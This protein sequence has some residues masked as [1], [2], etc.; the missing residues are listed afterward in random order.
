MIN[1]EIIRIKIVQLTYAYYQNGNKN[2][3]SAEKELFFSL[4]KAYDLYNYMLALIV[5]ITKE[6]RRQIEIV[7]SRARREGTDMPSQKFAY[8]RFALQLEENKMLNDFI[9]TQKKTWDNE[10]EFVRKLYK[11]ITESQIYK[12]YMADT[13]DSYAADRELWRKIYRTLIQE[14][15]ELDALLEEQSLYWNDDKEIVDTFVLKTI[16]RFDEKNAAKQE[17]LPEYDSE[18]DRDYARKLFRATIMNADEYQRYMSEASHNWDFNRLAY[19]DIVIMQIALAEI[20]TFPTIPISVTINE[21]VDIAKLY[22]TPRSGGYINGMLD[23]IA[24]HLI[25][26]GRLMKHM[27]EPRNKRD[28]A[29]EDNGNE[30]NSYETADESENNEQN[31]Q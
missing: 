27:D 29:K 3:D 9:E 6:A 24:R 10:I 13:D 11:Q 20:M 14:N 28:K 1:R 5:S 7:Q 22:S 21:F 12:D 8:N 15:E 4:S 19:M 25:Q 16:K 23:A 2:I 26:T 17:L 30:A 31:K 18:E